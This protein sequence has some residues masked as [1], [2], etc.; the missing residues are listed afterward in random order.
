MCTK[1]APKVRKEV[2][3]VKLGPATRYVRG[4]GG[5]SRCGK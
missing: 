3:N 2:E 1:M 5:N 4:V